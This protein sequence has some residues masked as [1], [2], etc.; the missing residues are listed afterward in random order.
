MIEKIS[1]RQ[2]IDEYL[3]FQRKA[4]REMLIPNL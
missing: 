4:S 3:I 2:E 1:V